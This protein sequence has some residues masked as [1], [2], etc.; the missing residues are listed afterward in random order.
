MMVT[1]ELKQMDQA[2]WRSI[3]RENEKK[4]TIDNKGYDKLDDN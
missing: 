4:T 1:G 2:Q 3:G